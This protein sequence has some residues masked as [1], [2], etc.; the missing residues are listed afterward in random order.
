MNPDY[1]SNKSLKATDSDNNED[2][3]EA[4]VIKS[5]H[6]S[7][8]QL[9]LSASQTPSNNHP[10]ST[11]SSEQPRSSS[12]NPRRSSQSLTPL[13]VVPGNCSNFELNAFL[14]CD[15]RRS[16]SPSSSSPLKIFSSG[17]TRSC[18]VQT[19]QSLPK[20][21]QKVKSKDEDSDDEDSDIDNNCLNKDE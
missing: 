21:A 12:S 18:S 19:L 4:S 2:E 20:Q 9:S 14:F 15:N 3:E 17:K 7:V 5:L 16:S 13:I 11:A 1:Q 10:I 8:S 6:R